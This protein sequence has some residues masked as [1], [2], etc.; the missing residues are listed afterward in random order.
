M[1]V[2]YQP[3]FVSCESGSSWEEVD[4]IMFSCEEFKLSLCHTNKFMMKGISVY[5]LKNNWFSGQQPHLRSI[6]SKGIGRSVKI[7]KR[8]SKGLTLKD[9]LALYR[10]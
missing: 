7:E 2:P 9:D 3:F 8:H 10:K 6:D 1:V 5:F 4:Y